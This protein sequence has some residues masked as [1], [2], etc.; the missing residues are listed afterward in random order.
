M[1]AFYGGVLFLTLSTAQPVDIT[2]YRIDP[3]A[4]CTFED[5]RTTLS[6]YALYQLRQ[7]S[8]C[9]GVDNIY[10]EIRIAPDGSVES[11]RAI[12]GRNNC[13]KQSLRDIILP[14]RW[15]VSELRAS[16]P[17]YYEFRLSEEC[18][19]TAEDNVYKPIPAPT[20]PTVAANPTSPSEEPKAP[21]PPP[22]QEKPS[23]TPPTPPSPPSPVA[24]EPAEV[25]AP[26]P[27]QKSKPSPP[28]ST[29]PAR[30]G[31]Q[32]GQEPPK[33][34]RP[35]NPPAVVGRLPDSLSTLRVQVPKRYASTG[36]KRPPADH[37]NSYVNTSGPRYPEP[38]YINGPVAKALYL[39]QEY[40]KRGVCGLVHV[41]LEIG[42]D[43][44]GNIKGY[45]IL[46]ANR[47][48]VEVATPQVL[49]GMKYKPVPLPTIFYTEFKIDVD[50]GTD[51]RPLKLD[52]IRD[53][54]SSPE[55][56]L[57]QPVR[58]PRP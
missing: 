19:G 52:T 51:Q 13:Y 38:E 45:R 28:L 6:E 3:E 48:D 40:R 26:K 49:A 39:K 2:R 17:F 29:E 1:R 23:E 8:N 25:P 15:K 50:C 57:I 41:L 58:P 56:K 27:T 16:R 43:A 21:P 34:S 11:A 7:H 42:I 35:P 12:T 31:Y 20:S 47:P 30:K 18:K 55:G 9:C 10:M 33:E 22:S 24:E 4:N 37:L 5:G 54:I 44:Q 53:F 14:T 36:E 46:R 32:P